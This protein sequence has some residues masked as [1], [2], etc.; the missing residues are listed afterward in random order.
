MQLIIFASTKPETILCYFV[1]L[2]LLLRLN[3]DID[4]VVYKR[5]DVVISRL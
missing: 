2:L 3:S 5:Y 4:I 1:F